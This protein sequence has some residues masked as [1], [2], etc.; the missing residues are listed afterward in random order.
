MAQA[1][2][3]KSGN[4]RVLEYVGK[5]I[6]KSGYKSFTA[7][8]KKEAE[9]MASEFCM[10]HKARPGEVTMAVGEAIDRYIESKSNVLSPSTIREYKQIRKNSLPDLMNIPLNRLSNHL[11]Q[12]AFNAEA[13]TKSPKTLRNIRGLLTSSLSVFL[14]EF[15]VNVTLPQKVRPTINIPTANEIEAL[16]SEADPDMLIAIRLAAELGLRR[17]ELCALTSDDLKNGKVNICKAV[18]QNENKEWIIKKPKSYA[19]FRTIEMPKNLFKIISNRTGQI[20]TVNP[21]VLTKRF[22]DLQKR[23]WG[24]IKFRFHDLRHYHAS[25]MLA[26][27]IPNKYAMERMGHST[28]NM[29]K[30]VYQH[31]MAEKSKEFADIINSHFE[32]NTTQNTTHKRKKSLK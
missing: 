17:S 12:E 7:P 2:K 21:N 11:I 9:Y 22:D 24:K 20:I 32:Q 1:K 13:K 14:P 4:W 3:L 29:L 23:V 18:V 10:K 6:T 19:G 5:G 31:T 25:L 8:T 27:G 15:R 30:T 16:K 26:L 28:D